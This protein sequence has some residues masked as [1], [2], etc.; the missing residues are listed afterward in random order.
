MDAEMQAVP[1]SERLVVA[2][3][4]N[5]H[6]GRDRDGYDGVHG[7]IKIMDF[8]TAYEM[9]LMNTYYKKRENH[10][11]TYNSG[12]R[13]SQIDFIMLRKEYTNEY[14][15]ECKNCKVQWNLS[16]VNSHGTQKNVH[17]T[18]VFT[19]GGEICGDPDMFMHTCM[20]LLHILKL[21]SQISLTFGFGLFDKS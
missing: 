16:I 11:V 3:D 13:R 18:G 4:L 14:T 17:Y 15:N 5:G 6:V 10:L 21:T 1:R 8:A 2:G 9:R 12:G 7:G 19:Q 20:C